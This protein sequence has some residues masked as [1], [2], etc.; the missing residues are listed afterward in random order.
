MTKFNEL[1]QLLHRGVN[2][3]A[4]FPVEQWRGT[5]YNDPG[6]Q[7]EILKKCLDRALGGLAADTGMGTNA[8]PMTVIEVG[9]FVGESAIF[10]AKHLK[11]QGK[12]A[13]IICVDTWYAGIDHYK[14]APEKINNHFGRPD[15]Y[16]RFM[17]NVIEQGCSDMILPLAIDSINGAR[18]LKHLGIKA[19][20]AYIDAS[21]EEGDV[22]RD[23][24]AYWEI[25]RPGGVFVIDDHSNH[26]PGVVKDWATF[27]KKHKLP[28][29][30]WDV[31]GEKISVVKP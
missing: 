24:E 4:A 20:F 21:H 29:S 5:W 6:A 7:R 31:A 11:A 9:S 17:A 30:A 2:P 18:L 3:Y 22:L 19:D 8:A 16:Y 27:S 14:G 23:Y 12:D 10:M 28:Q 26:F 25:M 13:V 1:L 15:L